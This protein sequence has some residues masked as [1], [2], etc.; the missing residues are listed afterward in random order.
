[1]RFKWNNLSFHMKYFPLN[2]KY[3]ANHIYDQATPVS[4]LVKQL[5]PTRQE[6]FHLWKGELKYH[7]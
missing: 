6:L 2:I 1:M 5:K 4:P 7:Q 3:S